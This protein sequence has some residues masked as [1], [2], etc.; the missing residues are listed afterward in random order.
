MKGW[1]V[2]NVPRI[3]EMGSKEYLQ[4]GKPQ[5]FTRPDSGYH[6]KEQS[7]CRDG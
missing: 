4:T 3:F 5:K 6:N 2:V 1:N 7:L